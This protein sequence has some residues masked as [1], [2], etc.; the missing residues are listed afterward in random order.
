MTYEYCDNPKQLGQTDKECQ[1][2][3]FLA[4][5]RGHIHSIH[6]SCQAFH[7]KIYYQPQSTHRFRTKAPL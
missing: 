7:R 2:G 3:E 6:S 5:V 1:G 4:Y